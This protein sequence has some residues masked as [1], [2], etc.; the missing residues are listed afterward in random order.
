LEPYL[1]PTGKTHEST[2]A[3]CTTLCYG[4]QYQLLFVYED[5]SKIR[6]QLEDYDWA[7]AAGLGNRIGGFGDTKAEMT[8]KYMQVRDPGTQPSTDSHFFFSD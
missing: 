1:L 5:E 7:S 8:Y 2:T 6:E 3:S 4:R